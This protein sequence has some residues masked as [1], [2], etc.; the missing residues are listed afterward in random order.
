MS[1]E[2]AI[3]AEYGEELELTQQLIA[4]MLGAVGINLELA[5]TEGTVMWADSESGGLEQTGN[6]DLN[7]WDDGYPGVDPTDHIWYYY[8]S[9]ASE[10]DYGWNVGRWLNEDADALIDETYYL[11]EEYYD[12][13]VEMFC[14][15]ATLLD[16][17]LPE[18]M[19]FSAVEGN[20]VSTRL[21]GVQSSV[22]DSIT[23][24]VADWQLE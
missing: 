4:E 1:M 23:W 9:E 7:M 24:N 18:I 15:L 21:Q 12:Y 22:N 19:L 5:M 2:F 8:Y 10:P 14:E 16:E 13:R 17:E 11:D 20:G 3:Y 6:F